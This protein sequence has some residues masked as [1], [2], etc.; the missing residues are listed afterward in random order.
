MCYFS[1][2]SKQ[3]QLIHDSVLV[4]SSATYCNF[5][6]K[7]SEVKVSDYN[8]ELPEE[9]IAQHP[10]KV[11][12][13]SRLLVLNKQTREVEHRKYSD[14]VDYLQPG[15]VIVLNDTKVIKARLIAKNSKSQTR[16]LLLLEDHHNTDFTRRRAIY[17]GKMRDGE[18]LDV[19]GAE[20]IVEKVLGG[21]IAE[22]SSSHNIL[23]I[24][25]HDGSVP[26]P[27]YM[28]R[29]A[30]KE[31]I[32]RYQTVFAKEP[33][34]VAAPTAS[35]NFTVEIEQRLREKGVRIAYLTLHVGLGT[36][37]PIRS[38][39]IEQHTMHSEYFEVPAETIN[40]I[41]KAHI[42]SNNIVAVGTTVTRTLE[43]CADKILNDQAGPQ[44]RISGE[45]D[46]FIYPG[47]KFK[48]VDAM[49]TNF[50]APKSTVLMMA[51]A[52]AGW[53]NLLNV[54]EN[55]IREKYAFLSYGDSMLIR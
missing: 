40:M 31:D 38:D 7:I 29:N 17:R 3:A 8:Y 53:D 26:L 46:I 19:N 21:G 52:F 33:G 43:Y 51:A 39:E 1:D 36:F 35:L 9:R 2:Q 11:R 6:D 22:I 37:L 44:N 18:K 50:H 27:P 23:D 34:S 12:G 48:L 14:L 13:S 24:A 42:N 20:I 15:D 5:F 4:F 49:L 28:H 54:Y 16:E 32:E 41:K 45:C 55:A 25:E 47:Y 10:P 30:T